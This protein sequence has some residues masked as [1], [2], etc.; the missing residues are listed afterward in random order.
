MFEKKKKY[1][2][3]FWIMQCSGDFRE[4]MEKVLIGLTWK[5]C[6]M[7]LDDIIVNTRGLFSRASTRNCSRAL[8]F[9]R[10]CYANNRE[11]SLC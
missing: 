10:Q 7:Y 8:A 9:K 11:R 4:M 1:G 6:V 3:G 2:Y 5:T